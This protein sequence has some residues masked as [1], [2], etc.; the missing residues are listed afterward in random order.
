M[1]AMEKQ[2]KPGRRSEGTLPREFLKLRPSEIAGSVYFST[3]CCIFKVFE[4][5]N[6]FTREASL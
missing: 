4:E 3:Y 1:G 2:G 5:G 6:Q